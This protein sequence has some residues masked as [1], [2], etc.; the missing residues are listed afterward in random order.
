MEKI[1]LGER[2]KCRKCN[3]I[4]KESTGLLNTLV[5]FEDFGGD[6]GEPGT[7]QSRVGEPVLVKCMKCSN[8]GHSFI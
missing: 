7:T 4:C 3:S 5:S 6:R 8:C 2:M 1:K